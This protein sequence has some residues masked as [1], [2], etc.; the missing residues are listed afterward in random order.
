ML[1]LC[2]RAQPGTHPRSADADQPHGRRPRRGAAAAAAAGGQRRRPPGRVGVRSD[3]RQHVHRAERPQDPPLRRHLREIAGFVRAHRAEGTWPGGIHVELTGDNVTECLGGADEVS[4]T[5]LDDRYETMCDPRLN[6]RQSLDLAF[7]VAEL[8]HGDADLTVEPEPCGRSSWSRRGRSPNVAGRGRRGRRIVLGRDRRHRPPV[9]AR[10]DHQAVAGVG[11]AGRRRGGHRRARR[12]PSV[13]PAARCATCSPTPAATP[14]TA[15]SRSRAPGRTP[16]LLEH[17]H[18]AGG[19]ARSSDAAGMPFADYLTEAVL[20]AAR[21]GRDASSGIAR[22]RRLTSTVGDLARLRSPSCSVRRCSSAA[23]AADASRPQYPDLGGIVPGVGSFDPCPW[24]LGFEIRG[25]KTPHWTGTTNCAVDVRSLRWRRHDD[26]GRPGRRMRAGRAHRPPVRRL[27]TEALRAAGRSCRDAVVAE[28]AGGELMIF[29]HG[30]RV[31]W[32][33]TGDD[34][35]PLVRYGFVGGRWPSDRA[36]HG[37]ARRRARRR[38]DRRST[39]SQPVT[40]TNVELR[41]D[42]RRP[43]RRSRRCAAASSTCGRPRP[44]QAGLDVDDLDRARRR[45]AAT[46]TAAGTLAV[47]R[48]AASV[49]ATPSRRSI[50]NGRHRGASDAE[51][52]HR[53][54]SFSSRRSTIMAMPWPPP[55]HIV[56][57]PNVPSVGLQAVDQRGHDAGAGHAE[58]VAE[59]DRRRRA[60]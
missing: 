58:R 37:D 38:R 18:R 30:D 43:A 56:S 53:L 17:R 52:L 46:A 24:G 14:S 48:R 19:R 15:P 41:L 50:D 59:G 20:A 16:D 4:D 57:R 47:T 26:V 51:R 45:R 55:T 35:L 2:E 32:E 11:D 42:G 54:T 22:P 25:H 5:D 1:E 28:L 6:G 60:R 39:S 31:R 7:R 40:I 10:V 27:A 34:G 13:S 33:T 29:S 8:D 23:G 36:G 49:R 21:H 12:S 3:A 44:N 9:P